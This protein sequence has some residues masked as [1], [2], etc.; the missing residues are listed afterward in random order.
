MPSTPSAKPNPE[1]A[2]KLH[3]VLAVRSAAPYARDFLTLAGELYSPANVGEIDR[4]Q[5]AWQS[6]NRLK[7][8]LLVAPDPAKLLPVAVVSFTK[9]IP[10]VAFFRGDE[11]LSSWTTKLLKRASGILVHSQWAGRQLTQL[12]V[13]AEK[14]RVV[15]PRLP[16]SYEKLPSPRRAKPESTPL[17][18]LTVR[19]HG[20][21]HDAL[22][23]VF[24][25]IYRLRFSDPNLRFR[26][27]VQVTE[28]ERPALEKRVKDLAIAESIEL[29]PAAETAPDFEALYG[30]ADTLVLPA[31]TQGISPLPVFEAAAFG[32]PTVAYDT[33]GI[34]EFVLHGTTG[35]SVEPGNIADL[36]RVLY[37]LAANRNLVLDLGKR[38]HETV[39]AQHCRENFRARLRDALDSF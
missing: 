37:S 9:K 29:V 2:K 32:V 18:L 36:A 31:I 26:F 39:M 17:T 1:V 15:P 13:P 23:H 14:L 4:W 33:G 24:Q 10:F 28:A 22:E 27:L 7:P 3:R 12:G 16:G 6:L 25:V 21:D 38:A 5:N 35:M 20:H 34:G 30:K 8:T 11:A 19:R